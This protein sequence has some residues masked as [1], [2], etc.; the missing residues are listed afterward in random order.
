MSKEII[1][2]FNLRLEVDTEAETFMVTG[3]YRSTPELPPEP[4]PE[5]E[6]IY[7]APPGSEDGSV[8]LTDAFL[9]YIAAMPDGS[10]I[11]LNPEGI[12]NFE[13]TV[14]LEGRHGLTI[15]G[16]G[17]T[18]VQYTAGYD[19]E[20]YPGGA[21]KWPRTRSL[22]NLRRCSGIDIAGI[23]F[24]GA[25]ENAGI[26]AEGYVSA[27]E[28]QHFVNISASTEITVT[29][30]EVR[31]IFGDFIYCG[32]HGNGDGTWTWTDGVLVEHNH[33]DSNG[34]QGWTITGGRNVRFGHN[35][36]GNVRRSMIDI[37]PN[38][39]AGGAENVVVEYNTF[40]PKRLNFL[41]STGAGGMLDGLYI[42]NN[43]L[44]GANFGTMVRPPSPYRRSNIVIENNVSDTGGGNP[45]Q[46]MMHFE[47]VDGLIVRNN[48][49]L[50][51]AGRNMDL[52]HAYDCTG[53]EVSGNVFE[54]MVDELK[55]F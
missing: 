35:Y 32:M 48:T 4:E 33:F 24:L 54:N 37:E 53:V 26:G 38:N 55:Q 6:P 29:E 49:G 5:P 28:G 1:D 46:R 12:Y 23:W 39:V 30:C 25:H 44:E 50:M 41:A 21:H 36:L 52:V 20:P 7:F 17:A 51:Q 8:N 43:V 40:G 2:L 3:D 14:F 42:R 19:V 22:F 31:N 34:R 10:V 18:V 15:N 47:R 11:E 13:G 27:L 9:A 16:N 45:Q